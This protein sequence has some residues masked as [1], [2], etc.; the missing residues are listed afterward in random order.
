MPKASVDKN[1]F[2]SCSKD[3]VRSARKV[4]CV[5]A[6]PVPEICQQTPQLDFGSSVFATDPPHEGATLWRC[7]DLHDAHYVRLFPDVSIIEL[8]SDFKCSGCATQST[9]KSPC[10]GVSGSARRR[11]PLPNE[12][13]EVIS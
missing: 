8:A 12:P 6:I 7:F 9:V 4:L 11:V 10:V 3:N 5:E 2:S 13:I 1:G